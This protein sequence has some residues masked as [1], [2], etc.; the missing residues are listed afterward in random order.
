MTTGNDS[1]YSILSCNSEVRL[2][3]TNDAECKKQNYIKALKIETS[4]ELPEVTE[5]CKQF[6]T[7]G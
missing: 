3:I 1:L 5:S 2:Q 7:L 6:E 4:N